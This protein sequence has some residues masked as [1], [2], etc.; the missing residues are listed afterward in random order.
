MKPSLRVVWITLIGMAIS[1]PGPVE[2][3]EWARKMFETLEHDFGVVAR[4]AKTEFEFVLTNIY[5]ED[6][7]IASVRSSCAC[8]T[9]RIK[10][11][12]LKTYEKSAI[13]A[14]YNTHLFVGSKGA[15]L[16]VVFD[17][18]F[19]A[20]VQLQV[21]G[22]IRSDVVVSP[23]SVSLG[24]LESGQVV[25]RKLD[26][27]YAG[28]SDWQILEVRSP[29]S[30]LKAEVVEIS[31]GPGEVHYQLT[32]RTA[33]DLPTGYYHD[34]LMLV[35]NDHSYSQLPVPVEGHI[36]AGITVS[37]PSLFLGVVEPGQKITKKVVVRAAKPFRI[38]SIHSD[39]QC[40]EFAPPADNTPKTVHVV[41]VTFIAGQ[42]PGKV[43]HTIRIETDLGAETTPSVSAYA[44]VAATEKK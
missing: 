30:A 8:T 34:H 37:P 11:D 26:I 35:T 6:V 7:H 1:G 25:E 3:Q 2:A 27:H 42:E 24:E 20:E 40:F 4:G 43:T 5:V 14:T 10:K 33:G 12:W 41:P 19:Y 16:T 44:V 39:A 31:R 28:R 36:R 15:T 29:H 21:R 13:V 22:F 18:P 9:P 23:P 17:K 32:V 38:V